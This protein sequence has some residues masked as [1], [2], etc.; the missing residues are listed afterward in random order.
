MDRVDIIACC[1]LDRSS[2]IQTG[3]IV[4]K[5]TKLRVPDD[6]AERP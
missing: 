3:H 4:C 1:G 2:D 5:T 6:D